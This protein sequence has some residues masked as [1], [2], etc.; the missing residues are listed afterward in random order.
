MHFRMMDVKMGLCLITESETCG[1]EKE[2][3]QI[4]INIIQ[5]IMILFISKKSKNNK[6]KPI[7]YGKD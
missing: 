7:N 6:L 4:I 3:M 2:G 1:V 5:Y